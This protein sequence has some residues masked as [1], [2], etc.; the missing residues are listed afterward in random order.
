MNVGLRE[1]TNARVEAHPAWVKLF[2]YAWAMKDGVI[3][4]VVVQDGIPVFM[5]HGLPN[6]SL[7]N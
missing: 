1:A 7:T 4:R 2:A 3:S 5:E 6:I